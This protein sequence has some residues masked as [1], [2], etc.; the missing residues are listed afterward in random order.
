MTEHRAEQDPNE[1]ISKE[2]ERDSNLSSMF[3]AL[4]NE[5]KAINTNISS[6]HSD[7]NNIVVEDNAS[8]L[9]ET[10]CEP[11]ETESVMSVDTKVAHL[12]QSTI[13]TQAENATS[14]RTSILSSIAQDLT[15]S[16]KTGNAIQKALAEIVSSLLKE[17][18]PDEKVRTKL[19]KYP[20]PENVENLRTPRVNPL[21][22]NHVTSTARTT[23]AKYQKIQHS[24]NGSIVAMTQ[25]ADH[26]IQ[27]NSDPILITALTDGIAL[28][29]QS[30]HDL[31]QT[32]RLVM[33]KDL[34][35]DFAALCDTATSSGELLFGDL[36]KFTKDITEANKLTKKVRSS[37][38]SSSG[39]GPRP[40]ARPSYNNQ[41]NRKFH[42]Y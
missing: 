41:E 22:W 16:E 27:N 37:Q 6:M 23:D 19:E 15:V 12:L 35:P 1:N 9:T 20:S 30:Q 4:L 40:T 36:A 11:T 25:A 32:R 7:L 10:E 39:R 18:L 29:I 5:M 24:L 42:P 13:T 34:H 28:A 17:K 3:S 2:D 33:K 38:S 26:A 14:S 8:L 21:I 31:N